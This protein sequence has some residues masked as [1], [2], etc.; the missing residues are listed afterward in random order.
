[1]QSCEA[2]TFIDLQSGKYVER[3]SLPRLV[4][5]IGNFDGVHI[6]HKSLI[7]KAVSLTHE[8]KDNGENAESGVFF[9]KVPPADY[10]SDPAPEHICSFERKLELFRSMGAKYAVAAD[11][12]VICGMEAEDFT[13]WLKTRCSCQAIV[14]GFNFRFGKMGK[15]TPLDLV[16]AFG[17]DAYVMDAVKSGDGLPVSSS[18]IR[19]MIKNGDL[20]NANLLLGHPF[21]VSGSVLHGKALGRKLGL[22][23]VNQKFS[24]RALIPK[25]GIY[26]SAVN[27]GS[28][29]FRAVTNIGIRPTVENN[30][31]MN[32]ETH[33]LDFE[34]DLYGENISVEFYKRLRDEKKFSS[35]A[36]L[37]SAIENDIIMARR[38]F[39]EKNY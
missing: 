32:C 5:A 7:K 20:E 3:D 26:V 39:E 14:C 35:E 37:R 25:C 24:E 13:E 27:L 23:T 31:E 18:R 11:F 16:E 22:P 8:K 2:L 9:F 33:L 36:E 29:R 1:M 12:S 17:K 30:G 21:E 38:Y 6:G 10:L 4:L 28:K 15:G 34:G 19:A